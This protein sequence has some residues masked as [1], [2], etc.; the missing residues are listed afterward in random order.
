[1]F[2]DRQWLLEILYGHV[3]HKDRVL[4]N[5][6]V[7]K[8]DLVGGGVKVTT[9]DGSSYDG[10]LLI[11]ADGIYSQ[12]R[13]EM[14][15]LGD[16]LQPGA[17]PPDASE[18]ATCYYR[19]SFGIA[20]DF[21]GFQSGEISYVRARDYNQL[22][23]SGP[24]D[25]VYWFFFDRLPTPKH[26]KDIPRYTKED[27]AEFVKKFYDTPVTE[28][29]TFG[30]LYSRKI[31]STLTP[32]HEVV[33]DK[34]FFR[35][36]LLFGD[37]IHKVRSAPPP[38][39][40]ITPG[41]N[42]TLQPNP[43][44]GQGGNSAIESGAELVNQ[45]LRVRDSRPGGLDG[46]TEPEVERILQ[47][48]QETR[49]DRVKFLVDDSHKLEAISAY[50]IPIVS[51]FFLRVLTPVIGEAAILD[52]ISK[53]FVGAV[54]IERLP[55]PARSVGT[56]IPWSDG[57]PAKPVGKRTSWLVSGAYAAGVGSL[58]WLAGKALRIPLEELTSWGGL[59]RIDRPWVG[60]EG[61]KLLMSKLVSFFSYPLVG[62]DPSHRVQL[63]YFMAE[64]AAPILMYTVDGYRRANQRNL[65]ALPSAFLGIMQIKAIARVAPV[66]AILSALHSSGMEPSGNSVP[67]EVAKALLPAL[68]LGYAIP[69]ALMLAPTA[70]TK[71]W[72]DWTAL[73]QF[74]P[75]FVP[76]L[77]SLISAGIRWWN[78][79]R[80]PKHREQEKDEGS[81]SSSEGLSVLKSAYAS[82][83]TVQA[84][85]HI[86][87]LA[88]SRFHPSI[89]IS[90]MFF[91]VPN[92]FS[93][94]W[95][96]PDTAAKANVFLKYDML[97]SCTASV[98]SNLYSIWDL[99]RKGYVSTRD[100][101]RAAVGVAMGVVAVGPGA[102]WMGL[103]YWREGVI[104]DVGRS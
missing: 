61:S 65:L 70:N 68:T 78:R 97:I 3:Q 33:F 59:G 69:T 46:L 76:A 15:R 84:A 22:I 103:S 67:T 58:L 18:K 88:Y 51:T 24:R 73:W 10:A 54:Q 5:K 34:W 32:L 16:Q 26:G 60:S 36:I 25:R 92:P 23:I 11:G 37:S 104:V 39:A 83:F 9:S 93:P 75:V 56:S 82:V 80:G 41:I 21:P 4:L 40:S 81:H 77:T 63:I 43:L 49:H 86:A 85:A 14:F 47:K 79:R 38:P 52:N 8:V 101:M 27:E 2:F 102:T 90:D 100:A 87:I 35:R 64:L 42:S 6:R 20:Q 96:L 19:C 72:Q 66:H 28:S 95:N 98:A 44:S 94:R 71:I 55:T 12:V 74:S 50:E 91:G 13:E 7:A 31:S 1:M 89:S 45:L 17:F 53:N 29:S 99:R 48:V 62:R 57:L 30:E